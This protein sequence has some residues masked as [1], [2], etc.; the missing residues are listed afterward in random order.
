MANPT[1]P[2]ISKKPVSII[3]IPE[4]A[5]LATNYSDGYVASRARFTRSR[6]AFTITYTALTYAQLET[7]LDFYRETIYGSALV[8]DWTN[9]DPNSK[10]YNTVFTVRM[11]ELGEPSFTHPH[12]WRL[13]FKVVQ[14]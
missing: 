1:F 3:P 8:F 4:D 10:Y 13:T 2:V 9:N 5:G 7:I 6:L 14:I 12:W 11:T